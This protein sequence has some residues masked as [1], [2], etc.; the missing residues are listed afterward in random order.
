[1]R[2]FEANENSL[3]TAGFFIRDGR[4]F[5]RCGFISETHAFRSEFAVS[6]PCGFDT[7]ICGVAMTEPWKL[8][9]KFQSLNAVAGERW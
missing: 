8:F 4:L 9:E 3:A 7:E 6:P 2:F 1:M 5:L